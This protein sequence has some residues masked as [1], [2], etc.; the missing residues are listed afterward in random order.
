MFFNGASHEHDR[1][2][3]GREVSH[4]D[5]AQL[6]YY[7]LKLSD[8]SKVPLCGLRKLKGG[9]ERATCKQP[10]NLNQAHQIDQAS[11]KKRLQLDVLNWV[12]VVPE[13][14]RT[15]GFPRS[16]GGPKFDRKP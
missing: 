8:E 3:I 12:S 16:R 2:V 14:P 13:V 15:V 1:D 11:S 10:K 9:A 5:A 7:A 4:H 6:V